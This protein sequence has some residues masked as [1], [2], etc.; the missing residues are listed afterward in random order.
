MGYQKISEGYYLST[1]YKRL[2]EIAQNEAVIC[3]VDNIF[4]DG[5][6]CRD[7]GITS[8]SGTIFEILARGICYLCAFNKKGFIESC[9]K[10]NV[11]FI[12]P[13]KHYSARL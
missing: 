2:W 11:E 12:D 7:V 4:Q 3:V 5:H 10:L 9:E 8:F 13:G 6:K 1:D